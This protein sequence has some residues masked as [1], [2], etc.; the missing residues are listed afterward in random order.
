MY[1]VSQLKSI[2]ADMSSN[3]AQISPSKIK[4]NGIIWLLVLLLHFKQLNSFSNLGGI[5][6]DLP[7]LI[8]TWI[9]FLR[10]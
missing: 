8:S 4:S 9:D 10:P 6:V 7:D 2:Q 3:T 5:S 1:V